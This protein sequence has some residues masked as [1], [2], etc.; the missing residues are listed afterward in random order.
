MDILLDYATLRV[1]WWGLLGVLLIGFAVTDGYDLGTAMLLPVV[2][3]SDVERR[4]TLN[5]IGPVWEGNQVW[6]ILGAGA[7][8]AAFPAI[9][10]VAFSGFYIAMLLVLATLILRP[11][12]FDFRNKLENP[13]WRRTWDWALFAGGFVPAVVF[14]V[15]FGNLL[16]GVPFSFDEDLRVSY[17]GGFFDLLNPFALV[18]GVLSASMLAMHGAAWLSLKT[19]GVIRD[20]ARLALTIAAGL[21]ALLF[22]IAGVWVWSALDG[23]AFVSSPVPGGPSNPLLK[24]V[25]RVAGGWVANYGRHPWMIIAPVVGFVGMAL[26]VLLNVA[27]RELTALLSSGLAVAG[28]IATAGVSMFPFLMPSSLD[29]HASLTVWDATSSR[30]TL[31][32]MLFAGVIFLPIILAYTGFVLRVLRGKVTAEYVENNSH[33]LY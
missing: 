22:A 18:S 2:A 29:P 17:Q 11:V 9:Y 12:G 4:V 25:Q 27:R 6:L 10:A 13:V 33:S 3:R 28:V 23:Y 16:Q 1:I 30:T 26:A 15:A 7:I 21:A 24:D 8:F 31:L 20:R 5:C 32:L 14:G 19:E